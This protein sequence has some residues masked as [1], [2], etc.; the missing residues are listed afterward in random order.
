MNCVR[1]LHSWTV[2]IAAIAAPIPLGGCPAPESTLT[3]GT[4]GPQGPQGPPGQD[5]ADGRQGDAGPAGAPGADGSLRIYGDGS[6]GALAVIADIRLGDQG[7]VNLQFT[8]VTVA[9]GVTL[10]VQSGTVIRCTGTFTNAGTIV[11]Q[12]GAEGADRPGVDPGT[13]A[14]AGRPAS[15]GIATRAA[16]N[17]E[18]G[19]SGAERVA[20]AGGSGLSEFETRT[21]LI[22]G[23][24]AGGAGGAA[25]SPGGSGG[26][27]LTVLALGQ[28]VNDGTIVADGQAAAPGGGGGG[29]GGVVILASRTSI[30]QSSD[31]VIQTLGGDGGPADAAAGPGGGG[32]GGIIHLL[33]PVIDDRG[34]TRMGGGA[35]G[36]PGAQA[37]VTAAVRSGGAGGGASAGNG[38]DG[39]SVP[40]GDA[41]TP[42]P[43]SPG[44]DGFAL[45]TRA[46]PSALFF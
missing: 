31:A 37:S 12:S 1:R 18:I 45:H 25:L 46:D 32:G 38:G 9:A 34:T 24:N 16:G 35:P 5:G 17:G 27:A 13:L 21:T 22:V 33:S 41:A 7:D 23:V 20:G 43:A 29:A 42:S 39:G 40:P 14:P 11:V 30:T 8:D 3:V 10:T 4:V 2:C 36:L 6:A 15:P 28:L 19:G 44:A 26:G